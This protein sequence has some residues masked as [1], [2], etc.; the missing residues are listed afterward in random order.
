MTSVNSFNPIW[1]IVLSGM[2]ALFP[3]VAGLM[4]SY[5]KISVVL[6]LLRNALGAQQVPSQLVVMGLTMAMTLYIM[7]PILNRSI[8]VA[9]GLKIEI[10]ESPKLSEL[11][12]LAPIFGP[13]REFL[14]KHAGKREMAVLAE[15]ESKS[16]DAATPE[17]NQ[18]KSLRLIWTAFIITELKQAFA[19][20]FVLLIPFLVIDLIVANVLV[21]MGM[22]MVSPVLISLPIKILIF[23]VADG[24]LLLTQALIKSYGA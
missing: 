11:K 14:E 21:G 24:W 7:A 9:D 19:M 13:W 23:V 20:G 15:E 10:S 1:L 17:A 12:K 5:I 3:I 6:G 2:L 8:E 18:P 4:T 16:T 22:S